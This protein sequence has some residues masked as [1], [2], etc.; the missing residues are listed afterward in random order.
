MKRFK[1]FFIVIVPIFSLL[2]S[3]SSRHKF[4]SSRTNS[5]VVNLGVPPSHLDPHLVRVPREFFLISHLYEGLLRFGANGDLVPGLAENISVSLDGLHYRVYL[6]KSFWSDGTPLTAH[7]FVRSWRKVISPCSKFHFFGFHLNWIKGA[8]ELCSGHCDWSTIALFAED[9]DLLCFS[10][11]QPVANFQRL[12]ALPIFFPVYE[13]CNI[14]N[15][16]CNGPFK[17]KSFDSFRS[18]VLEKND[19]YWNARSVFLEEIKLVFFEEEAQMPLFEAGE[20]DCVGFLSLYSDEAIRQQSSTKKIVHDNSSVICFLKVNTY[21]RLLSSKK[22]RSAISMALNRKE[23]VRASLTLTPPAYRYF[24]PSLFDNLPLLELR[25]NFDDAKRLFEEGIKE[26]GLDISQFNE[27]NICCL[28]FCRDFAQVIQQQLLKN[29]GIY[30]HIVL[31]DYP[32]Y[33]QKISTGDFQLSI[34]RLV[35]SYQDPYAFLDLFFH[36]KGVK[37]NWNS[38]YFRF[39]F[40]RGLTLSEDEKKSCIAEIERHILEELPVIPLSF[41][42]PPFLLHKDLSGVVS[43]TYMSLD[44]SKAF[45]I[46]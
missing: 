25:E 10:L 32:D 46:K 37:A 13:N 6:R 3:Y 20:I 19:F 34:S 35:A 33:I 14:N 18:L 38:D 8:D 41:G 44:F 16:I 23:L 4:G 31:L 29:L 39:L 30:I 43:N 36:F 1:R 17:M 24:P 27:L 40:Q 11:K 45:W 7:D 5:L 26:E 12:L 15:L 9:D 2:I 22:V 42:S 28:P 21:D